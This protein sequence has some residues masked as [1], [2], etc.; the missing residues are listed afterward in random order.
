MP[1]QTVE[2]QEII[3]SKFMNELCSKQER[4]TY[5][6]APTINYAD[7]IGIGGRCSCSRTMGSLRVDRFWSRSSECCLRT[8]SFCHT[9]FFAFSSVPFAYAPRLGCQQPTG[10]VASRREARHT[11]TS[12][13]GCIRPLRLLFKL[14]APVE[15]FEVPFRR[16]SASPKLMVLLTQ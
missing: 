15:T 4:K 9:S 2:P 5:R 7:Y 8:A 3:T 10:H 1:T 6:Q 12:R 11:R 13:R 16:S 14:I